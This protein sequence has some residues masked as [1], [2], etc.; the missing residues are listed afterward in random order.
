MYVVIHI[1]HIDGRIEN[2][3]C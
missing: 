3:G 2:A 1:K